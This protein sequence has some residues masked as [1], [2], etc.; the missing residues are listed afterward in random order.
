LFTID[1][2]LATRTYSANAYYT[3]NAHRKNLILLTEAQVTRILLE[4]AQNGNQ[5]ATGVEFVKDNQKYTV[6]AKREVILCAGSFQSPQV[7]ELSGVGLNKVLSKYGIKQLIDLP[8]GENFQEHAWVPFV[9]EVDKRIET[10]DNCLDPDYLAGQVKAYQES[11]RGMLSGSFS[12][13]AYVPLDRMMEPS[14]LSKF[15]SDVESDLTLQGTETRKRQLNFLKS[16]FKD[17]KHAQLEILQFPTFY[18]L[19]PLTRKEDLSSRYQTLLLINLHPLSRGSIHIGSADPLAKPIIDAGYL[20]NPLDVDILVSSVRFA[21]KLMQTAPYSDAK[22]TFYDPPG[23]IIDDDDKIR[24]WVRS[25]VEPIYHPV[26]T[27]SM[28]P[29]EDGGVVNPELIVYGTNNVRVIDA[30]ILP[31]ELS[32]HIQCT[33]YALAEKA[34]DII[35]QKYNIV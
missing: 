12:G 20:R 11:K 17:T 1:P 29:R 7:L 27:C 10:Y 18:S 23:E 13:Y 24:D 4:R 35:K 6:K 2:D 5:T 34:A 32:S 28:L 19:G 25:R 3:P 9:H 30:S 33:V 21:R 15:T 8:V 31:L 16:W 26:G 22:P 14:A